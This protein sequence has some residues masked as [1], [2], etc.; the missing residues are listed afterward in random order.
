MCIYNKKLIEQDPLAVE[1]H[2]EKVLTFKKT[3]NVSLYKDE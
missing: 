1:I 3:V 2:R